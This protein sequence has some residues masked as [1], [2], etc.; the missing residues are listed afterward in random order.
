MLPARLSGWGISR[1]KGQK[2]AELVIGMEILA[3]PSAQMFP[4]DAKLH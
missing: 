2:L 1:L 4:F 3:L